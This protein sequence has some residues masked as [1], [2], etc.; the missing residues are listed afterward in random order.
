[1][2]DIINKEFHNGLFII[3]RTFQKPIPCNLALNNKSIIIVLKTGEKSQIENDNILHITADHNSFTIYLKESIGFL[4]K[5]LLS[6]SFCKIVRNNGKI[7]IRN[8]IDYK[9][10]ISE[11]KNKLSDK[12]QTKTD[13]KQESGDEIQ[14]DEL[15]SISANEDFED[16]TEDGEKIYKRVSNCLVSGDGLAT[17]G[18]YFEFIL[19]DTR[20]VLI[21]NK[22]EIF[23]TEKIENLFNKYSTSF[24]SGITFNE[25]FWKPNARLRSINVDRDTQKIFLSIVKDS[26]INH[27]YKNFLEKPPVWSLA[28]SS[29]VPNFGEK[30]L[31]YTISIKYYVE[32]TVL[33]TSSSGFGLGGARN[34][35]YFSGKSTTEEQKVDGGTI[36]AIIRLTNQR[37][38]IWSGNDGSLLK[39]I[40]IEQIQSVKLTDLG[41]SSYALLS[42]SS[43]IPNS[44]QVENITFQSKNYEET[45]GLKKVIAEIVNNKKLEPK[46]STQQDQ[47]NI[48]TLDP[49]K[50][51]KMRFAKGEISEK[52]YLHKKKILDEDSN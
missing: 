22:N 44:N 52:E 23:F 3:I 5:D 15:M 10:V 25:V 37:I 34:S 46:F 35:G 18:D 51:L 14:D 48:D 50:V 45:V 11:L 13:D 1:M 19:T 32:K 49:Q 47:I 2:T 31:G 38:I 42:I 41:I 4:E 43:L 26:K 7:S 28:G 8:D 30:E 39:S 21:N 36:D 20:L 6:I 12:S 9:L 17:F 33:K 24:L 40:P 29:L 27:L 16:F